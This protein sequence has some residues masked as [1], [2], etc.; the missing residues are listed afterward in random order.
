MTYLNKPLETLFIS[1]FDFEN[2]QNTW[3]QRNINQYNKDENGNELPK[4]PEGWSV[5]PLGWKIPNYHMEYDTMYML[6]GGWGSPTRTNSTMTPIFASISGTKLAYAVTNKYLENKKF[7]EDNNLDIG[8]WIRV[9]GKPNERWKIIDYTDQISEIVVKEITKGIPSQTRKIEN[10]EIW[11]PIKN[12][13]Y[14]WF[15]KNGSKKTTLGFYDSTSENGKI[16]AVNE[17]GIMIGA[18]FDK[19]EP[20]IGILPSNKN[21]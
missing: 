5:L 9:K 16:I 17:E 18:N 8:I 6:N 14:C 2:D 3:L 4:L 13:E 15:W 1:E 11:K 19:C 21:D 7:I 20:F 12:S 10:I